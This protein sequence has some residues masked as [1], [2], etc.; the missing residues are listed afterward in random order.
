MK[1]YD[2]CENAINNS[3]V[4]GLEITETTGDRSGYPHNLF[5][6]V[7]GFEKE[8][9]LKQFLADNPKFC[10]VLLTRRDGWQMPYR[11]DCGRYETVLDQMDEYRNSDQ[12]SLFTKGENIDDWVKDSIDDIDRDDYDDDEEYNDAVADMRSQWQPV[13]DA[14]ASLDED[15]FLLFYHNGDLPNCF[16]VL[17]KH[18]M[19]YHDDDVMAYELGAMVWPDDIRDIEED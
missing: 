3:P 1:T 16:E 11:A 4:S 13:V 14:L 7:T 10:C 19:H 17:P 9:D 5:Y 8:Q 18:V 15:H 12:H 6:V 2:F